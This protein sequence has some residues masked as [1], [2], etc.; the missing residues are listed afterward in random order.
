MKTFITFFL[1]LISLF[2]LH[3]CKNEKESELPP[4]TTSGKNII[5]G[6]LDGKLFV[7]R[8]EGLLTIDPSVTYDSSTPVFTLSGRDQLVPDGVIV[9]FTLKENLQTGKS[10]ITSSSKNSAVLIVR[11]SSGVLV[12]HTAD[13]GYI[14]FT[15]FDPVE[16]VYSGLFE[17]TFKGSLGQII[18]FKE[19]RFDLKAF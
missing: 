1:V 13:S 6:Y 7:S 16:R 8:R 14:E 10:Q 2:F 17:V 4:A 3:A 12:S 19:G 5:A 11:E 9:G 15:R 18:H